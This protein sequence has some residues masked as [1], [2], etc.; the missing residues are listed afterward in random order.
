MIKTTLKFCTMAAIACSLASGAA[1]AQDVEKIRII[2]TLPLG[3][4]MTEGLRIFKKEVEKSTDKKLKVDIFPAGQ[5]YNDSDAVKVIPTGAVDMGVVQLDMWAGLVPS[6]GILYMPTYY[7]DLDHYYAVRDAVSPAIA[8][9]LE[10][11]GNVKLLGW[12]DYDAEALISKKQIQKLEDFKGTKLRGYGEYAASFLQAVGSSPVV[13]SSSEAYDAM[14]KGTIDGTM[15]GPTSHLSRKFYEVGK[16]LITQPNFIQPVLSYAIMVNLDTWKKMSPEQQKAV[17]AAATKV[18]DF[19]REAFQ[20]ASAKAIVELEK[21]GLQINREI[22]PAEFERI[23]KAVWP[24]LEKKYS[25]QVGEAKA[26]PILDKVN[27]L[28]G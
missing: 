2:G 23:K 17:E 18:Q 10:E 15:S 27:E 4:H 5:L 20:E 25:D 1:W 24:V 6:A 3:H 11:K 14:S 13:M 12:A 19:T 26:K 8:Q 28:R 21:N 7:N 9:D 22:A 16:Y